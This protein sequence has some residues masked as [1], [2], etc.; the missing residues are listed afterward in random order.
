VDEGKLLTGARFGQDRG[1][2]F[3]H[4][5]GLVGLALC[6][7]DRRIGGRVHNDRWFRCR[8]G[9]RDGLTISD[10]AFDPA[11]SAQRNR[12]HRGQSGELASEL[13]SS[14][15]QENHATTP[16]RSPRYS[17]ERIRIHQP[18]F[19]RNQAIVLASPLSK[20]SCGDQPSS[21]RIRDASMA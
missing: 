9:V 17:P 10:I 13:P 12:P 15:E 1:A 18:R 14:P 5:R 2:A 6:L 3:V 19:S 21:R 20:V 11:D 16:R 4:P 7:V 8:N